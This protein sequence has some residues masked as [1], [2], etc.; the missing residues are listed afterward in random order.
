MGEN[1]YTKKQ[2]FYQRF[3]IN[4]H[5]AFIEH[6]KASDK[7]NRMKLFE[8]LHDDRVPQQIITY[9]VGLPTKTIWYPLRLTMN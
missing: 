7:V 2:K 3:T 1:R 8:M 4:T 9:S 5:V 6:N